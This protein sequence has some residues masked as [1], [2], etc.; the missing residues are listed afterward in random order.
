MNENEIIKS[1]GFK[2]AALVMAFIL[3]ALISFAGGAKI[4]FR[5]ALFSCR[6]GENYERNFMG[7]RPPF[8][9]P[10]FMPEMMRGFEGR[11]FRNPHG[12]SGT[13]IS[14]SDNKLI[15]KDNDGKENTV[16][17]TDKTI[18]NKTRFD[19][20]KLSDLKTDDKVVVMGRPDDSGVVNAIL[21]RVFEK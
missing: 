18:I 5:K 12:L 14:I 4:G 20:L 8:G 2:I 1:K 9:G 10:G 3:V 13:I 15:I 17:V 7:P 19:N 21:I 11:D 6:W 16:G